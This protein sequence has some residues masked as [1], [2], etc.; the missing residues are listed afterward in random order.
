[1]GGTNQTTSLAVEL[2]QSLEGEAFWNQI[3]A[4]LMR[5]KISPSTRATPRLDHDELSTGKA[6][7]ANGNGPWMRDLE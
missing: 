2:G 6:V 1:L 7:S 5:G 4:A 3:S